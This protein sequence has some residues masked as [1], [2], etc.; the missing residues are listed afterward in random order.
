M[1]QK[2]VSGA[3]KYDQK[4]VNENFTRLNIKYVNNINLTMNE[5]EYEKCINF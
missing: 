1:K 5:L 4:N 3:T 2:I